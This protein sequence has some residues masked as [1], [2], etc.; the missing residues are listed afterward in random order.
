MH[1]R[2]ARRA[3]KR[4]AK[5]CLRFHLISMVDRVISS[6]GSFA[7]A[8]AW[9]SPTGCCGSAVHGGSANAHGSANSVPLK[10]TM[11]LGAMSEISMGTPMW[12]VGSTRILTF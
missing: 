3:G 6:K 1:T 9:G 4:S 7:A 12:F 8:R 11:M 10:A 5:R 2:M